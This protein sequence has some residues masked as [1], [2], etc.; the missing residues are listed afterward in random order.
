[1]TSDDTVTH[2]GVTY[3]VSTNLPP[4]TTHVENCLRCLGTGQMYS[5][6]CKECKGRGQVF[7]ALSDDEISMERARNNDHGE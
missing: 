6:K 7:S 1:M 5:R 4:L 3:R 2:K